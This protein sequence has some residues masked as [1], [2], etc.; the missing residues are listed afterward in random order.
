M[1]SVVQVCVSS[2]AL[3]PRR[4]FFE[5]Q[6]EEHTLGLILI[7]MSSLFI[8]CQSFKII[9]DLYELIVCSSAGNLG[10]NCAISKVPVMNVITRMSHLLVCVNSST[11]ILIYYLNGEKFRRAW[12]ETY[13]GWFCCCS[14]K[15]EMNASTATIVMQAIKTE[16]PAEMVG[17]PGTG[18][19]NSSKRLAHA[20][21][22]NLLHPKTASKKCT[23]FKRDSSRSLQKD[24]I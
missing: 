1:S 11:N 2:K 22:G 4:T 14:K 20:G 7:G 15:P 3:H 9:P 10:H 23:K 18:S 8:F 12:M 13:G 6:Q 5:K 19:S 24:D 21:A 16:G 17:H